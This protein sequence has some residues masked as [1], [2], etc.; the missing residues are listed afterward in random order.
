MWNKFRSKHKGK[1]LKEISVLYQLQKS[2]EDTRKDDF[3]EEKLIPL[4]VDHIREYYWDKSKNEGKI[5]TI[6]T[7]QT[8]D[9][10][11]INGKILTTNSEE[12]EEQHFVP[13]GHLIKK[14]GESITPATIGPILEQYTEV[15]KNWLSNSIS[16]PYKSKDKGKG[17]NIFYYLTGYYKSEDDKDR[18]TELQICSGPFN[19]L[20]TDCLDEV[21]V[22]ITDPK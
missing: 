10:K 9:G 2:K 13:G 14:W 5:I 20:S 8:Y 22:Y 6:Y 18:Y 19:V 12:V 11:D 21:N 16:G 1:S 15:I 4:T 7:G 17:S 3:K